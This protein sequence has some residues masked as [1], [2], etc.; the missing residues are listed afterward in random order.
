MVGK[1]LEW[2]KTTLSLPRWLYKFQLLSMGKVT[3][4]NLFRYTVLSLLAYTLPYADV[5]RATSVMY[6]N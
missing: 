2:S 5:K 6:S 3:V 1:H 4:G